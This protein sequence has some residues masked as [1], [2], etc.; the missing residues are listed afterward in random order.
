MKKSGRMVIWLNNLDLSK[1]REEGRKVPK[2]LAIHNPTLKEIEIIAKKLGL[3]LESVKTASRP[4]SWWEKNGY[5]IIDRK[6][7]SRSEILK[8]LAKNMR[9]MRGEPIN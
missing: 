3:K 9:E 7:K 5:V 8:S 6:G 4:Q 2:R 1:S